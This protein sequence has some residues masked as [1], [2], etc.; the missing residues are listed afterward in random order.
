[1][2]ERYT[3]HAR[4]VIFFAR[5]EASSFGSTLIERELQGMHRLTPK[6][7]RPIERPGKW[8]EVSTKAPAAPSLEDPIDTLEGL[9]EGTVKSIEAYSNVYGEKRLRRKPW[10]RKEAFGHLVDWATTH[11]QW[12]A[13]AL[14]EPKVVASGYPPDEW[15]SAQ[16]YGSFEWDDVGDLWLCANR[17]L[18]HVLCQIPEEK[19]ATPFHIGVDQPVP[20]AEVID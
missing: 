3:E 17:L 6:E 7:T 11:Q 8:H 4:R 10:S 13:R 12:F 16:Q 19:L 2:F 15:V 18:V 1:M 14:V 20:L 9:V 5:Y